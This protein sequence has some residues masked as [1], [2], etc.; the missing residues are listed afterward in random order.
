[1]LDGSGSITFDVL[2]WLNQ[3]KVPLVKVDWTGDV[4]TVASGENFAASRELVAWQTDTRSDRRRIVGEAVAYYEGAGFAPEGDAMAT[5]DQGIAGGLP[6]YA[7]VLR[8][9]ASLRPVKRPFA[10]FPV[11]GF[12]GYGLTRMRQRVV[13]AN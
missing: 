5:E 10:P 11:I 9:S 8:S 4:V 7:P 1:M 2:T 12:E 3:Q 13:H 6:P